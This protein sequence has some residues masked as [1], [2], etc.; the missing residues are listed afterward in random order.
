MT[1]W[2]NLTSNQKTNARI[3][4]PDPKNII[5]TKILG[6]LVKIDIFKMAG[7]AIL[8]LRLYQIPCAKIQRISLLIFL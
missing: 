5:K 6:D 1:S 7:A 3:M 4:F 8:D 2:I